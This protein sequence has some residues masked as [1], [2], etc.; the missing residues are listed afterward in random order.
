VADAYPG[1]EA[2]AHADEVTLTAAH[3]EAAL[4]A[5]SPSLD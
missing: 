2:N 4:D 5:V 3:F 1:A